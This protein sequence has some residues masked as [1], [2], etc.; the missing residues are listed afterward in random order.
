MIRRHKYILVFSIIYWFIAFSGIALFSV[1]FQKVP[2]GHYGLKTNYFSPQI[3]PN[4]YLQG[5]YNTGV[6]YYFVLFPSTKQYVTDKTLTIINKNLERVNVTY[7]LIYRYT[8]IYKGSTPT[9]ST[10]SIKNTVTAT[11]QL[12]YRQ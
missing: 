2:L 8:K 4:Y 9:R 6:G 5:L 10:L 12:S 7:S 3:D 1:S 11:L